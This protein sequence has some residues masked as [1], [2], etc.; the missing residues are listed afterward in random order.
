MKKKKLLEKKRYY[1]ICILM[2]LIILAPLLIVGIY[3]RPSADDF[4]YAILTHQAVINNK[5]LFGILK[6]AWKTNINFFNSWQG[7]YSSAFLLALQPAIFGEK[8]YALTIFIIVIFIFLFILFSINMINKKWLKKSFLFSVSTAFIVLTLLVNWLPSATEGLYWYNGAMNYMPWVFTNFFNICLL[9]YIKDWQKSPKLVF[10]IIGSTILSFLTSGG[11]HVT[12][13]ANILFLIILT[14]Y[15]VLKKKVH[16]VFP[17]VAAV[18]GFIIMYNAP[19]TAVRAAAFEDLSLYKP[20][21]ISTITMVFYKFGEVIC[22][23]VNIHWLLSLVVLTP[24]ALEV[25]KRNKDKFSWPLLIVT[26]FS[27]GLVICG[28]LAVPYYAMGTF[29]NG[30]L[31]NVIW[32]TFMILSWINYVLFLGILIKKEILN[33]KKILKRKYSLAICTLVICSGLLLST[34]SKINESSNSVRALRELTNGTAKSY[35][36]QLDARYLIFNDPN[37]EEAPVEELNTDSILF[38]DDFGTNPDVWPN[39]SISSYYGKKIYIKNDNN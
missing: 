24:I 14:I 22:E 26:L 31:T 7:L 9:F 3:N 27:S 12:A 38:F 21:I 11:N 2:C 36:E 6:A 1:I 23:W 15:F 17:L 20:S 25:V 13:F 39:T 5:G 18:I 37:I 19:G 32:L 16:S 33:H 10:A 4:D 29:G 8:Y 34:F 30:R 28:M 35:C